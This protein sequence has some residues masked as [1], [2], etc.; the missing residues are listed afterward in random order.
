[1]L[2]YPAG[3]VKDM[4]LG[5]V[6]IPVI[7]LLAT[8]RVPTGIRLPAAAACCNYKFFKIKLLNCNLNKKYLL[9]VTSFAGE[10]AEFLVIEFD[11]VCVF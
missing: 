5:P 7:L 6:T 4:L 1:M 2:A 9:P 8:R 10:F 11:F 3:K